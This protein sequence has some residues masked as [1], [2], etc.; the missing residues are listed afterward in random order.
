MA[1]SPA[2]L[3]IR[4][5]ISSILQRI[6]GF[7]LNKI[8]KSEFNVKLKDSKIKLLTSKQLEKVGFKFIFFL[9]SF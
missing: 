8:F 5:D 1:N 6:T 3:F 7:D 4:K 2:K 9:K